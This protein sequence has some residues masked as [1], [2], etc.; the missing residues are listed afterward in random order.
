M[1]RAIVRV[2][3]VFANEIIVPGHEG[4]TATT[5][6][7]A[8]VCVCVP[9][10]PAR[11]SNAPHFVCCAVAVVRIRTDATQF[12]GVFISISVE[13]VARTRRAFREHKRT[14]AS[15]YC[16]SV[17]SILKFICYNMNSMYQQ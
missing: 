8:R 12:A 3:T 1:R 13:H 2:R 7:I 16:L 5:I 4:T 15:L 14:G 9:N 17:N 6:V 11:S 10:N